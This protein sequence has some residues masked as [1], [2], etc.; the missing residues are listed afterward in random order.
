MREHCLQVEAGELVEVL[1]GGAGWLYG[2]V[3]GHPERAG[4]FPENRANWLGATADNEQEAART[5]QGVLVKVVQ[6]FAPGS[7]GDKEEEVAFADSCLALAQGDVVEVAASGGGWVYGRVVGAP[8]RHGYFPET[9]VSWLGRPVAR[10]EPTSP[11]LNQDEY[12]ALREAAAAAVDHPEATPDGAPRTTIVQDRTAMWCPVRRR[13]FNRLSCSHHRLAS[14]RS[15]FPSATG[16]F[17]PCRVSPARKSLAQESE[18]E[19]K[20]I[21]LTISGKVGAADGSDLWNQL[22][23]VMRAADANIEVCGGTFVQMSDKGKT[24]EARHGKT[25]RYRFQ[26]NLR[27][28][29]FCSGAS[30][31][32]APTD[33]QPSAGFHSQLELARTSRERALYRPK[34]KYS[35]S[36]SLFLSALKT[37]QFGIDRPGQLAKIT[38]TLTR[39]GVSVSN[40]RVQ[41]GCADS[42][43]GDFLPSPSGGPLAENR[44]RIRFDNSSMDTA[45]RLRKDIQTVGEELGYAVTCLTLDSHAQFGAFQ[46]SYLLQRRAF[47]VCYLMEMRKQAKVRLRRP[48]PLK[49]MATKRRQMSV[50]AA[51]KVALICDLVPLMPCA[52]VAALQPASLRNTSFLFCCCGQGTRTF[53]EA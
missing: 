11:H 3:A 17:T 10:S 2:Q 23:K 34:L 18:Q 29:A 35:R 12:A 31:D 30:I 9:R 14:T 48:I 43:K 46:P 28:F 33:A 1:A 25:W 13:I 15:R 40:L 47:V 50:P 7:P 5:Q 39:F 22:A 26:W 51:T 20:R 21:I 42:S 6:D 8:D 36:I 4:Y 32:E 24:S 37:S 16:A 49:G 44:I 19:M 52:L 27:D 53:N 38:E 41:S 45:D